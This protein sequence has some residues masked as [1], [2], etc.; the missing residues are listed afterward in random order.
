MSTA[1]VAHILVEHATSNFRV[2][3]SQKS[4][5]LDP[6]DGISTLSWSISNYLPVSVA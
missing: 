3:H 1:V 2:Y 6:T 5:L 4:E